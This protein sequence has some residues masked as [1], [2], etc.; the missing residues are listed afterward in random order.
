MGEAEAA[1]DEDGGGDE[2]GVGGR[3]VFAEDVA[4]PLVEFAAAAFLGFFE[5][6]AGTDLEPLHGLAEVALTSGGETG[7]GG[8]GFGAEGDLAAAGVGEVEELLDDFV[9]AFAPVEFGGFEDGDFVL[10]EAA[11][12]CGFAPVVEDVVTDGAEVGVEV[13][14]A[15][16]GRELFHGDWGEWRAGRRM[17][18]AAAFSVER[19]ARWCEGDG[20]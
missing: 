1:H 18:Q 13:A 3:G 8:S 17:P 6:E 5:A 14:E 15:W 2:V 4:V 20:A 12:A 19:E 10:G 16:E 7:E 9:A 11:G